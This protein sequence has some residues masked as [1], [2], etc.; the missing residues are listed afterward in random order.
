MPKPLVTLFEMYGSGA[1]QIGPRVAEALGV[2]WIGQAFSSDTIEGAAAQADPDDGLLSRIFRTLGGTPNVQDDRGSRVLY[3]KSDYEMVQGNTRFVLDSTRDGGVILGRNGAI[4]LADRPGSLHVLL[5]GVVGDRVARAAQ[6][7]GI[8]LA[9]AA[10][11]QVSED[12]VR[13]EMSRQLYQWDPQDPARYD[14]VINTSRIELDS[15]VDVIVGLSQ[16]RSAVA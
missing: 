9:R 7:A 14:L 12:A 4:I 5:T 1:E 8:D 2:P 13:A 15:A 10:R 16:A 6:A 11:R 3:D